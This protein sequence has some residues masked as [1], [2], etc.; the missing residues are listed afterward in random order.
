MPPTGAQLEVGWLVRKPN[1]KAGSTRLPA[2]LS[3]WN[4][5]REA[6]CLSGTHPAPS[7]GF[8][9]LHLGPLLLKCYLHTEQPL[10]LSISAPNA[11]HQ[12]TAK[13]APLHGSSPHSALAA[14]TPAIHT[15]TMSSPRS[16]SGI[17]HHTPP[18]CLG[19]PHLAETLMP[20][21]RQL[22]A[23]MLSLPCCGFSGL[24][25]P[26][27]QMCCSPH[28]DANAPNQV[29]LLPMDAYLAPPT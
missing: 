28:M 29:V 18:T 26:S 8:L 1:P 25:P 20:L 16:G 4:C 17:L 12:A 9:G 5:L 15:G 11:P 27:L 22:P 7:Q 24:Y 14:P 21:G 3:L 2:G 10:H 23:Q 6:S 13:A 19:L